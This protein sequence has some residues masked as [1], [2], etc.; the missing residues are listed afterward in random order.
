MIPA[1]KKEG[2]LEFNS[3]DRDRSQIAEERES[4]RADGE[5]VPAY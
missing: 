5:D 1:N 4:Q 2:A 3:D